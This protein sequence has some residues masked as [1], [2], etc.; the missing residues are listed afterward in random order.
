MSNAMP[1]GYR[2]G[3]TYV[4]ASKIISMQEAYPILIGDIDAS[5]NLQANIIHAP[6]D[7]IRYGATIYINNTPPLPSDAR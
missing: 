6:T 7:N 1:S 4:G 3:A 5:G 2:F